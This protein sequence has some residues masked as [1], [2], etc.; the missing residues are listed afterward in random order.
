MTVQLPTVPLQVCPMRSLPN[1]EEPVLLDVDIDFFTA[2]ESDLLMAT[3]LNRRPARLPLCLPHELLAH[4]SR[5][6]L[7]VEIAT[8]CYSVRGGYCPLRWRF[9]G[10]T[11]AEQLTRNPTGNAVVIAREALI[12][13][14]AHHAIHGF[15]VSA[16][17]K[18]RVAVS[19]EP[20]R[21]EAYFHLAH[22]YAQH[23]ASSEA[24]QYFSETICRDASYDGTFLSEG[25]AYANIGDWAL[26]KISHS[27]ALRMS[28]QN[29]Y[30]KFGLAFLFERERNFRGALQLCNQAIARRPDFTEAYYLRAR[31]LRKTGDMQGAL[32][33]YQRCV[34]LAREVGWAFSHTI[35]AISGGVPATQISMFAILSEQLLVEVKLGLLD[36][37][38]N[39]LVHIKGCNLHRVPISRVFLLIWVAWHLQVPWLLRDC[40]RW[41]FRGIIGAVLRRLRYEIWKQLIRT[42]STDILTGRLRKSAMPSW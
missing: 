31:L 38:K 24:E 12:Y 2:D 27:A 36:A 32:L 10:D 17:R 9:L 42:R 26:S 6:N 4:L 39:T 35:A 28:P 37:A 19:L 41:L 15:F 40:I 34:A 30:A 33:D 25:T 8:I 16:E 29:A 18:F 20:S 1:I 13:Q 14:G 23:G 5:L 3:G 21:P 11:L 22:L 7:P